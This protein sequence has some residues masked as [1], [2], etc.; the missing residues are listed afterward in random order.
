M[1][2]FAPTNKNNVVF[3]KQRLLVTMHAYKRKLRILCSAKLSIGSIP[4][5]KRNMHARLWY[6]MRSKASHTSLKSLIL[7]EAL[8][9]FARIS[10]LVLR[11]RDNKL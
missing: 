11:R 9:V 6:P 4:S 5:M 7:K 1:V 2:T 3:V 10:P 8:L